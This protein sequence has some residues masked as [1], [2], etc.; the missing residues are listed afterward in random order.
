MQR[1][2]PEQAKAARVGGD[3]AADLAGTFGSQVQRHGETSL[4]E[5][6]IQGFQDAPRLLFVVVHALRRV[7]VCE[8]QWVSE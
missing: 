8:S 7:Y 3:V 1:P 6:S 2:V 4:G 5:V